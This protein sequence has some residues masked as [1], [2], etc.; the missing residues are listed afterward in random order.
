M[1]FSEEDLQDYIFGK[2]VPEP[3]SILLFG[4][5]LVGLAG[6]RIQEVIPFLIMR[7]G[8]VGWLCL[9]HLH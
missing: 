9:L 8:R 7:K 2:A 6:V 5:V 1:L 3:G 4:F